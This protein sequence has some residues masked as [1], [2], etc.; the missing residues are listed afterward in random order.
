MLR[1]KKLSL[2]LTFTLVTQLFIGPKAIKALE[3]NSLTTEASAN[4]QTMIFVDGSQPTDAAQNRYKTVSE[5]VNAAPIVND[6]SSRVVI[7]IADGTYREQ[8]IVNK[9]YITFKSASGDASKVILT[10]YYGIG[11]VYNNIGTNGFYD[12]NVDWSAEST[13]AGLTRH[14]AGDLL[15]RVTYYDKNGVLHTNESVKG[16]IL[17]KP[18]RWGCATKL[19]TGAKYFIAD[20]ITFES[21]FNSYVTQEEIDAGVKP[22]PQTNPKPDRASLGAGSVEVEKGSY[23]ER[24][25]ALHTDS[26]NTIIRNSI[27]KS[28]QD[29]LYAGSGRLL[30]D[31]CTIQGGTDY[32]FGGATAV[33]N[34]CNLVFAGNSDNG[35]TGIVTAG[36]HKSTTPYGYLFWNCNVDYRQKDK[37]PNPGT[38]GRPWSDPLGAQV[39]FYNTTVKKVNGV[40]LISDTGWQDMSTK[41][42]EARFYE[43][44]SVDESGNALDTS[45][46]PINTL[47]PMGIAIDK[48]QILE[49]NPRNYLKGSDGWDPMNFAKNYMDIDE[50]LNSVNI[51]TS[52]SEDTILLPAAPAGYEFSWASDSKYTLVSDDK[53]SITV[54]RPAYGEPSV[55]AMVTLY[56]KNTS[57]GFG[58]KKS[59]PFQV[60]PRA[61]TDNTFTVRGKFSMKGDTT[62]DVNVQMIFMQ[63]GVPI[64][65]QTYTIPPHQYKTEYTA[66]FLPEGSYDILI[67]VPSGY[68]I[69][70]GETTTVSGK[71]D[72]EKE[73]NIKIAKLA[74]F[75]TKTTD[76]AEPWAAAI[77]TTADNGFSMGK[78]TSTGLETANLGG[79][80]NTVYKFTKAADAIIPANIGGY[81]DLLAAVKADGHTL[82]NTDMLQFSYDFLMET[83]DY[84]PANYSYFDLATSLI[85]A[86]QNAADA[87]RF[88][89]WG[90]YK[91]WSQFNMFGANNT[92]VNGDRTQFTSYDVMANKWYRIMANID[93]KNKIITTTLY[94]RDANKIL[95]S[96]AFT[97][98]TPDSAGNSPAYPTAADLTKALYFTIYMDDSAT[99]HKMEYYFDNLELQYYDYDTGKDMTE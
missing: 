96:R 14:K 36:S 95:N 55:N 98:A 25:A 11:Y 69:E 77:E 3:Q 27:I 37:I 45:K 91:S 84:L 90:V 99:T 18:D 78:Y 32:I 97:I 34:Q 67:K 61:T 5:A 39:T 9:P 73:I 83:A 4:S 22:E 54:I 72:Q 23:V 6:E 62:S 20:G 10:W 71:T 92:R 28:K 46:R 65:T 86:G 68:K 30:F 16:G 81:W 12:A 53:S 49:F 87:A 33:F 42:N 93:M 76:F 38:L 63:S 60:Q 74:T 31:H 64:K 66:K 35:N 51:N 50:V 7:S 29:T 19:N 15:S 41:V 94:N 44:G 88:I 70:S 1:N 82:D 17:G 75:T 80:G 48:W 85:N 47:A 21:T 79:A 52:G 24:S 57:T 89:R 59:I 2:A 58:D 26:D 13:W 40:Q 43:Y 56:A 8:I